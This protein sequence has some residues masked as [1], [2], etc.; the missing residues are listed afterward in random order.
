ME[1]KEWSLDYMDDIA[2]CANNKK[3]SDNLRDIFPYPYTKSDAESYIG[4]CI[5][6]G[7]TKQLCRAI[8]VDGRAVGSISV[9]LGEDIF[10]KSA[11]LGFWLAEEY[12]GRGIM[13]EAVRQICDTAFNVFE[14]SRIFAIAF[15]YNKGSCRVLEKAGFALEG[16][17]KKG[18]FKNGQD[19]DCFMYAFVK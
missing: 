9:T 14:I 6:G 18:I 10:G 12:W 7:D 1:L 19:V 2:R 15:S 3:I 16:V 4:L 13:T 5:S 17:M 8:L 11:E